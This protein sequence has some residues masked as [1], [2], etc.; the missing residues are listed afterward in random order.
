MTKMTRHEIIEA[1]NEYDASH[2]NFSNVLHLGF[3]TYIDVYRIFEEYAAGE[4]DEVI[5]DRILNDGQPGNL[6]FGRVMFVH[7]D[8]PHMMIADY[9][10]PPIDM[11]DG[12]YPKEFLA[13]PETISRL[14][15]MAKQYLS[16]IA[17][18]KLVQKLP[19]LVHTQSGRAL[20]EEDFHRLAEVIDK[21][22]EEDLNTS[23]TDCLD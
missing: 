7:T 23:A 2:D 4:E 22:C 14:A 5:K 18:A 15:G 20:S 12:D 3:E 10:Q 19:L 13:R 1:L 8:I 16:K 21:T 11:L 9:R 17:E 6:I